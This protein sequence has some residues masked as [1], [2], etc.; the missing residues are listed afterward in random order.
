VNG[1]HQNQFQGIAPT[2]KQISVT[3]IDI[4]RITDG[5]IVEHWVSWIN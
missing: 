5:K 3:A 2:G 4:I 1:T